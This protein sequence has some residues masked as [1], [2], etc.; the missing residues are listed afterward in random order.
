L[1]SLAQPRPDCYIRELPV[2]VHTK[3]VE[4]HQ[5]V[6]RELLDRLLPAEAIRP[7]EAQFERRFFLR[8]AE[9]PVRL[10]LLDPKLQ[11]QLSWPVTDLSAP[12]SEIGALN[13][14]GQRV[15]ITENKINFLTLP[16]LPN[17][18]ALFGGGFRV[19]LLKEVS[20]LEDCEL[21]YWGDLDGQGFQILSQL[22]R[23]FPRTQSL[24]MDLATFEAFR[25]FALP[26]TPSDRLELSHLTAE[27]NA[28]YTVLVG[29]NLRLEQERISQTFV[30][31]RLQQFEL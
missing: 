3:F 2:E 1:F 22:R 17:S 20:W 10:R 11:I 6:L 26:G 24:M 15:I 19:E 16:A 23:Y 30:I 25:E 7:D 13:L 14:A 27:E 5:G 12:L 9:P 4:T 8:Y 29:Q 21:L 31:Q 18:L 28:L